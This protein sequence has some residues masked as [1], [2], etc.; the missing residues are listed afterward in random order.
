MREQ[1]SYPALGR[2]PIFD[3]GK[4]RFQVREIHEVRQDRQGSCQAPEWLHTAA[5]Q[6]RYGGLTWAKKTACAEVSDAS[7]QRKRNAAATLQLLI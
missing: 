1:L 3:K 6:L 4:L 7:G 5:F 2:G